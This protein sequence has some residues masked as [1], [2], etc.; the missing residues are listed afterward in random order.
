MK[1]K[2]LKIF[3]KEKI[4]HYGVIRAGIFLILVI[5]L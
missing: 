3:Y 2:N 1:V 4:I 5:Q